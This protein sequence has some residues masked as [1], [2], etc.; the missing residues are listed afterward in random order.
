MTEYFF[1][2]GASGHGK[3]VIDAVRRSGHAVLLLVDDDISRIGG[4]LLGQAV[5]CSRGGLLE[6]REKCP[7]GIVAIGDNAAR[8]AVA[9]WLR[10][11]GFSFATVI[12]PSAVISTTASIG[13]G[14]LVLAQAAVNADARVGEHV[15]I[16]T[17]ATVDHDCV[18]GDGVHLAPGVHLC[19]G[20]G[21]GAGALVG[22]G[23]V[24]VPGVCIGPGALIGA[25][26]VVLSDIPADARAAGNPCRVMAAR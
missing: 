16:N 13:T 1:V 11:Q 26:S 4:E 19:G 22:A 21:V 8:V 9:A 20:V 15:I 18:V 3:V 6:A 10:E 24:V 17:A 2:F 14:T 7:R 12:D 25:G 5:A 23:A